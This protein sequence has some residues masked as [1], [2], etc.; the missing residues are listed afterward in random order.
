VK[1]KAM[2]LI[3]GVT[4]YVLGTR[5]GRERYEQIRAA[6]GRMWGDPRVQEARRT[7]TE[8]VREKVEEGVQEAKDRIGSHGGS[9]TDQLHPVGSQ[10]HG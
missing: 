8:Q 3:G 7:A 4:G 6:A 9:H 10:P 2:L 5:A 1:G